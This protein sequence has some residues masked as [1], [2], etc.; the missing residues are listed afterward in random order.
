METF[1]L[2][3]KTELMFNTARLL[4]E[5]ICLKTTYNIPCEIRTESVKTF[6]TIMD[7]FLLY[8]C[9]FRYDIKTLVKTPKIW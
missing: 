4:K 8:K 6:S 3:W 9:H 2:N 1:E 5:K 7:V